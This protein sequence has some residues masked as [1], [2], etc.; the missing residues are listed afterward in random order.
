MEPSGV[1]SNMSVSSYGR[2]PDWPRV[3]AASGS[4]AYNVVVAV[5]V[6][7][8]DEDAGWGTD[9]LLKVCVCVDDIGKERPVCNPADALVGTGMVANIVA[10]GLLEIMNP[11]VDME[12]AAVLIWPRSAASGLTTAELN[13]LSESVVQLAIPG[14]LQT[15]GD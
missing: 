7:T 4:E 3:Q 9:D 11:A 5:P 8:E 1:A 10:V 14:S 6:G 15:G 2:S 12:D 13:S